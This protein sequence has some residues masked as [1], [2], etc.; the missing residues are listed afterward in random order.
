MID[1]TNKQI[2]RFSGLILILCTCFHATI[3]A[4]GVRGMDILLVPREYQCPVGDI[5]SPT[6]PRMSKLQANLW[7]VFSDRENNQTYTQAGGTEVKTKLGF[8]TPAYVIEEVGN[9]VRLVQYEMG[10]EVFT[11]RTSSITLKKDLE[12][13]GWVNKSDLLLWQTALCT[14]E[15]YAIKGL[16]VNTA[17]TL[18]DIK[19]QVQKITERKLDLFSDP[20]LKKSNNKDFRVFDFLFV[21]KEEGDAYLVGKLGDLKTVRAV[22]QNAMLGWVSKSAIK[23]W[24]QRLCL[25]PNTDP[26]AMAERNAAGAKTSVYLTSAACRQFSTNCQTG[27]PETIVWSKAISAR[28]PAAWRRMPILNDIGSIDETMIKTGVVTDIFNKNGDEVISVEE[29]QGVETEAAKLRADYRNV[30]VVFVVD[31][32]EEMNDFRFNVINVLKECSEYFEENSSAYNERDQ[33]GNKYRM[34]MVVYRDYI[35]E[36][37]PEKDLFIEKRALTEDHGEIVNFFANTRM[38][39]CKDTD[40]EQAVYYGIHQA[41]RM[42]QGKENQTNIIV[43]LGMGQNREND[44][45]MSAEVLISDMAKYNVSL[46]GFQVNAYAIDGYEEFTPQ[47]K[48]LLMGS[49]DLVKKKMGDKLD[50]KFSPGALRQVEGTYIFKFD[51]PTNSPLPGAIMF[52]DANNSIDGETLKKVIFRMV[53]ESVDMKEEVLVKMDGHLRGQGQKPQMDEGMFHL[54]S[55]IKVDIEL[56]KK[57]SF[58]NIQLFVEGYVSNKCPKLNEPL[59]NYVV[60]LTKSELDEIIAKLSLMTDPTANPSKKRANMKTAFESI[61]SGFLG[62]KEAKK[63]MTSMSVDDLFQKVTGMPVR[64]SILKEIKL[65]DIDNMRIVDEVKFN[66]LEKSVINSLAELKLYQA[67]EK[68]VFSSGDQR[69]YWV[70]QQYFP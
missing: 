31:G 56:L 63:M 69:L 17:S 50:R 14:K 66:E 38:R 40:T 12:D 5:L 28:P 62:P 1:S 32:S 8:M 36:S 60:L 46:L 16:S 57:T 51:C 55:S 45:R 47:V 24:K 18:A 13:Y 34:G 33:T 26:R 59:Y 39:N 27:K 23:L 61:I 9:Y 20:K 58:D 70:P 49:T 21:Y 3:H 43:L 42:F 7:V 54:L 4:Q 37:C 48:K 35:E 19:G 10:P 2:G 41:V 29:F 67:D 65:S 44:S 6:E 22:P 15:K 11:N 68:N 53:K 64:G 52:A 30:N 25:E